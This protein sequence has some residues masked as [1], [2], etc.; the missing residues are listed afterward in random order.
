MR[1]LLFKKSPKNSLSIGFQNQAPLQ[2]LALKFLALPFI[3]VLVA[4]SGSVFA[5]TSAGQV[6]QQNRELEPAPNLVPQ[7]V[8][9]PKFVEPEPGTPKAGELTFTVKQFNFTGN[10]KVSVDQ[11][12]KIAAP[13][14]G[15]PVTFDDLTVL[16][17][18]IVEFYRERGWLVRAILPRQDITDGV[19]NVQIIEAKLGSVQIENHSKRIGDK[20][21][22][23][24]IYGQIPRLS[25]LS[26]DQ[27]E[28]ALLTLNDLTDVSVT[29]SLQGGSQPGETTLV[30]VVEDKPIVTGQVSVDNYGDNNTGKIRTS[31][32]V[33]G[34]GLVAFGD[35]LSA[36]GLYSEGNAYGRLSYTM[37]VGT[38]GLRVGVNGSSMEYR[39]INQSF[40]SLYANGVSSTGGVEASY[41]LIRTHPANLMIV[42]NWNYSNFKNWTIA[43]VNQDQ[44]YTTSVAQF[45][46]TGNL[47]DG[48]GGGA[49]NTGSLMMSGG[50]VSRNINGPYNS[51]Y[52]VAGSFSK[53]RYSLNRNQAINDTLSAYVAVSGQWASKNMD[54]SEQMYLGGPLNVRAYG[55]GQGAAS[56][57]NL[58]TF[59][60]RQNLPYDT[61]LAGFYD[62]GNVDTWKNNNLAVN[63]V[64]NNYVLQGYGLSLSWLGPYNTNI[65]GIWAQRTGPLSPSVTNYLN[66]NGGLSANRFWLTASIPL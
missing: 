8:P 11:L 26:L 43:G 21:V 3:A 2:P 24:W 58:T 30:L 63:S 9:A 50:D 59:E 22:E 41:P 53:M 14:I 62:I 36:Y 13:F 45:G 23:N 15:K 18:A 55:S 20:D 46:F 31:A 29:S 1:A 40:G 33:S 60:L 65:K 27:L 34:S 52:G 56:Q 16:T 5:Q 48:I 51:N 38:S 25:D 64:S 37:P 54:S 42:A 19:I 10:A 6:L 66:Q 39:V 61:Q 12:Q 57:G 44:T 17:D 28:R 4:G 49:L 47:L 35:Q 7:A 32:L